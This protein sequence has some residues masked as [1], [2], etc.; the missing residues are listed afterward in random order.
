LD[1]H[2]NLLDRLT[3]LTWERRSNPSDMRAM[4]SFYSILAGAPRQAGTVGGVAGYFSLLGH[5]ADR[6]ISKIYDNTLEGA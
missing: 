6:Y 5:A 1:G 2:G 3:S 4:D